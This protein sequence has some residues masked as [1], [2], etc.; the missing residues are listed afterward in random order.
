MWRYALRR[1]AFLPLI[2]LA[3]SI[4]TFTM[5]RVLPGQDPAILMAGQNARPEDVEAIH[6]SL[7]L[8]RP[9]A[10]QYLEWTSDVLRG[11]LGTTYFGRQ[12]ILEE[13]KRRLPASA[14]LVL[15]SLS[16][17]VV[18]GV[19]FGVI[20][21]V[22]RNTPIDYVVRLFAVMGQSVPDFFLL[23]LLIV[24]PWTFWNYS[25]PIGGSR[26]LWEDP[27]HNIRMYLPPALILGI[28]GAAGIMRLQRTTMLE[29]LRSD[30]VRTARAKGLSGTGVIIRHAFRNTLTPLVT[31]I[32]TSFTL[33]FAGSVVA[34][35]VMGIDGVGVFFIQSA[36]QRDFPV[37]QFLVLYT[38]VVVV[39]VNLIVDLS[40]AYIDPRVRYR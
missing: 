16:I 31:T 29:V 10:V 23:I 12:D 9:I 20:S 18:V 13:V 17:S 25:A 8:D 30:Y 14:E 28:G 34:E 24:I 15:L 2:M 39:I 11:D 36:L 40:Y 27:M 38:A 3:V 7:G 6:K 35:T 1:L 26:T 4:I 5:L 37:I 33:V 22:K 21:A 32:G 19:T